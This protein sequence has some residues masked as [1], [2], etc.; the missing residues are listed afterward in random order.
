VNT[1]KSRGG[2]PGPSGT[3]V[4]GTELERQL[5]ERTAQLEA[6]TRD[7][8]LFSYAVSHDLRAPLRAID[9][10]G[11]ELA[12]QCAAA[13]G[14]SGIAHLDKILTARR[15]MTQT[16]ESLVHFFHLGRGELKPVDLDISRMA[17]EVLDERKRSEPGRTLEGVIQ[18]GLRAWGDPRLVQA[19]LA[20]LMGNAW[21]FTGKRLDARI[22]VGRMEAGGSE[23]FF[24]RDNGVGFSM[25]YAGK[26]FTTIRR[27]HTQEEFE[28]HGLGLIRVFRAIQR[29]SG[30]VWVEAAEG[31]GATFYF[32]LP[33]RQ[34]VSQSP[35]TASSHF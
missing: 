29:H 24:V 31:R 22:E 25:N 33:A 23:A 35:G 15:R 21:K 4:V 10:F 14:P 30:R 1:D 13:L 5:A 26:L 28:G 18:P 32:T 2:D 19:V 7:F 17:E 3:E 16:I 11:T 12:D 8:E 9:F 27:M 34:A 20:E 6:V